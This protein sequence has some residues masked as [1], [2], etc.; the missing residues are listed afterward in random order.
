[1]NRR[2]LINPGSV[3]LADI[4][5]NSVAVILILILATLASRQEQTR[6]ELERNT[7]ITSILSRQIA[8][9]VVFNDLP[10][11]PPTVLHDYHSCD[12]PH[13]CNPLLFPVIELY[14]GYLRIYN[15]NTRIYRAELLR[16][17]NA[18][19][20]Y[21][22]GLSPEQADAIRMDIHGISDYYIALGIM[23]EHG[24][25][26]RH[27]H[28]L[29][30][31]APPLPGSPLAAN[32]AGIGGPRGEG[33]G[34]G[35]GQGER[36]G[37]TQGETQGDGQGEITG[38][39]LRPGNDPW[40]LSRFAGNGDGNAES[41]AF[42]GTSLGGVGVL[43][44]LNY[45]SLLPP[46]AGA[47]G[48]RG[49]RPGG[50]PFGGSAP[51]RRGSM[52]DR[53]AEPGP[54]GS[55]GRGG[56]R[57]GAMRMFLPNA[58]VSSQGRVLQVPPEH[59]ETVVLSYLLHLLQT[60][61]QQQGFDFSRDGGLLTRLASRPA[62]TVAAMPHHD[63]VQ[64]L[65][66]DLRGHGFADLPRLQGMALAPQRD[67]NRLLIEPNV[68]EGAMALAL[69]QPTPW[70]SALP[71]SPPRFLLRSYPSLFKGEALEMPPGYM[72]LALPDEAAAQEMKWRPVA[73]IDRELQDVA[74]GFV[75]A[76][77]EEG[78]LA[79]HAGVNQLQLDGRPAANPRLH[80]G[81]R[82]RQLTPAV[83]VV[84]LLGL[85]LLLWLGSG[86]GRAGRSAGGR[87]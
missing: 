21:L 29:G 33:L 12:I 53:N 57:P 42:E 46:E 49:R 56:G 83:W 6:Q 27:W 24:L 70:I 25:R 60:A 73:V 55:S 15:T 82:R 84:A 28:Y 48:G 61:R 81:D 16:P 79:I 63:L 69:S 39:G 1:M 10:S 14:D 4:L 75:Y 37:E 54:L 67:Y 52:L 78:R 36:Q 22:M 5:A 62:A 17:A 65:A 85:L 71:E 86:R 51:R 32:V 2:S 3:A 19:D 26:V 66:A 47:E 35:P 34:W 11:S 8:T 7:D 23:Q 58:V 30:E 45:D 74:I 44:A 43:N 68:M 76:G 40:S 77:M 59:Y 87:P 18:F 20:R 72:L 80:R 13:D 64:R 41:G 38:E 50:S 31:D 9:S